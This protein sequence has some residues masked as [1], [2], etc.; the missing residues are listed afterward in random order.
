MDLGLYLLVNSSKSCTYFA[1]CGNFFLRDPSSCLQCRCP[2]FLHSIPFSRIRCPHRSSDN[3]QLLFTAYYF[4]FITR[5]CVK[6]NRNDAVIQAKPGAP[7]QVRFF[8]EAHV[9]STTPPRL[10]FSLLSDSLLY[11]LK[12][13]FGLQTQQRF[14]V[15]LICQRHCDFRIDA[16][17]LYHVETMQFVASKWLAGFSQND[18]Q[19]GA[20]PEPT[21]VEKRTLIWIPG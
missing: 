4:F 6:Y 14:L 5:Y 2:Q 17:T 13:F 11:F 3:V 16:K 19:S 1:H 9:L 12:L 7:G 20:H 21:H 10:L 18:K 15:L 8:L